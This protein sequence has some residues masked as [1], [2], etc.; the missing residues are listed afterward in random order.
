MFT[1]L[2]LVCAI[3]STPSAHNT[4]HVNPTPSTPCPNTTCLTISEYVSGANHFFTANT[5][6]VF[7]PGEHTIDGGILAVANIGSFAMVAED[8]S[9]IATTVVCVN[10]GSF[11]FVN[12][13][14]VEIRALNFISCGIH[15]PNLDPIGSN[16]GFVALMHQLIANL[17]HSNSSLAVHTSIDVMSCSRG[18]VPTVTVSSVSN[19]NVINCSV[20]HSYV[21]FFISYSQAVF[22]SLSLEENTADYGGGLFTVDSIISFEEDSIFIGNTAVADGGGV[23]AYNSHLVFQNIR[24]ENNMGE[25]GGALCIVNSTINFKGDS[26]FTG[27]SAGTC[28]GGVF[29]AENSHFIFQNVTV[30]MNTAEYGGGIFVYLSTI[31]FEGDSKFIGNSARTNGGG[32]VF[33]NVTIENST[34]ANGGGFHVSD[35]TIT[36]EGSSTFVVNSA[37]SD[38]GGLYLINSTINFEEDSTFTG[39]SAGTCGG[40]VFGADNS[41]FIF[42]NVTVDHN[43]ADYGGGIFIYLS[44]ISFEGDSKFIGNSARTNGGGLVF[45][46]VTIENSTSA[47]GGGFH[48]SDS[49]ITFEGSSTFVGN[50]AGSD[51]GGLYLINSTVNFEEDSIFTGN[52][53]GTCGGGVFGADDSHFIFHNVTVE[54]NRAG[55][56]GGLFMYNSNLNLKGESAIRDNNAELRGGG[57]IATDNSHVVFHNVSIENNTADHGGGLFVYLST[58]NF[59]GVSVFMC[60]FAANS[61]GGIFGTVDS[62]LIFQDVRF[63]NNTADYGAGIFVYGSIIDIRGENS[64]FENNTAAFGAGLFAFSSIINLEGRTSFMHNSV[65]EFGGGLAAAV[66]A[67]LT[68]SFDVTFCSNYARIGGAI[69]VDDSKLIVSGNTSF[70]NNVAWYGGAINLDASQ[71]NLSGSNLFEGNSAEYSSS[72]GGAI[73]S[74]QSDLTL[75]GSISFINNTATYGGGLALSADSTMYLLPNNTNVQF[76]RNHGKVYG[77]AILFKDDPFS[78]CGIDSKANYFRDTCFIQFALDQY[79]HCTTAYTIMHV[80]PTVSQDWGIQLVF[81]SNS[82]VEAGSVLYG[83]TLDTCGFCA[84]NEELTIGVPFLTVANLSDSPGNASIISSDPFRVCLCN[85]SQPDCSQRIATYN[86]YPGETFSVPVVAVGQSNGIVPA[87]INTDVQ[88]TGVTIDD[89]QHIQEADKTCTTIHYT[90]FSTSNDS[91]VF[92]TLFAE[93][94]C[95]VQGDTL[96]IEVSLSPCPEG[97]ALSKVGACSCEER[98][99]EHTTVCDIND[100]SIEHVGEFWVGY[101]N[102]SRGLILHPHCPFDYCRLG[103]FSFTL[104]DSDK[105]CNHNRSGT[106]CGACQPGFNVILGSSQCL[107]CSNRFLAVLIPFGFAGLLLVTLLFICKLTVAAGTFSGLLFYANIIAANHTA[108]FPPGETN[109]LTIFIAW[110]NLDLGIKTCFFDGM[111]TYSKTW[112]QFAFPF[113][114]WLLV[115]MIVV[116]TRYS[117]RAARIIGNTNPVSVLATLFLL[118]YTKLLRTVIAVFSLTTLEY[119]DKTVAVWVHDG[120]IG[121]LDTTDAKH[122]SLFLA[123]LLVVLF[124]FLPYT[125]VL[126]FGQC[127]QAR[128]NHKMLWW[129]NNT[130]FRSFLDAYHAPYKNSHRYWIGLLLMVRFV[131]F[132]ISAISDI[133]SPQDPSVNLL[134]IVIT[135]LA[136]SL[137]AWNTDGIYENWY[138]NVLESSFIFNLSILAATTLYVKAA[139]GNQAAV[140]CSSVGFA[141]TTFF[142][143]VCYHIQQRLLETRMWRLVLRPKFK[144]LGRA[145]NLNK[146]EGIVSAKNQ[147]DIK[148]PTC[149]VVDVREPLDLITD[150]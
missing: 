148:A 139:G 20:E 103:T 32:L 34:S 131:L 36:F 62:H 101:D 44:T 10:P 113:Y 56:G 142:G 42:Q 70:F 111:N 132:I 51:G 1:L 145:D 76:E 27:N 18:R 107:R 15:P 21:P 2:L 144:R 25:Y 122:I 38:G 129:A 120:N 89:P 74:I 64:R 121:Y 26:I 115:G 95:G 79:C 66:K 138:L 9:T 126:I 65:T 14:D 28:G 23:Y 77:G 22:E 133:S 72:H 86:T 4:Y 45:E 46:N 94:P 108:F 24:L 119:P 88:P 39:N 110:L 98:L 105:Q 12:I 99:L 123:S 35:S 141:F 5:T 150:N 13:S 58:L 63:E 93:G 6:L 137:L 60:N 127:I 83:G 78:Y 106:L 125:L 85:N 97:F 112:L 41:H 143:I 59:E 17:V 114:I 117:Q 69:Y 29:G 7:L 11:V 50:S 40:G 43:A 71:L 124:L 75:N 104:V 49:T 67:T 84:G 57:I 91:E 82:A 136:L 90:I 47:N 52:S 80:P 33:E 134:V 109:V 128:S 140:V 8:S 19:F 118:S 102:H 100:K 149:T 48:V 55:Y 146:V 96:Q 81:E 87:L 16:V 130:R 30:E 73:N 135:T 68:F 54:K 53:A 61:G 147:L 37:G 31:D 92:L 3:P 116:V